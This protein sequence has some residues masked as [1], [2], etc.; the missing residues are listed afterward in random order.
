MIFEGSGSRRSSFGGKR[1][2][3]RFAH[4]ADYG[5]V[6]IGEPRGILSDTLARR[7]R[8]AL[9]DGRLPADTIV[10]NPAP[11]PIE[12]SHGQYRFHLMI[13][14]QRITRFEQGLIEFWIS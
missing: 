1:N 10:S 4:G 3:R 14:T 6:G 5:A 9:E 2:F 7:V 12:K 11:A 8:E 13:R